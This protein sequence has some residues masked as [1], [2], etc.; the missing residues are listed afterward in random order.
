MDEFGFDPFNDPYLP[1]VQA[2]ATARANALRSRTPQTRVS[3]SITSSAQDSTVPQQASRA[4]ETPAGGTASQPSSS[5]DW[6]R[7]GLDEL[8]RDPD[9]SGAVASQRGNVD[10]A[11]HAMLLALAAQQ[12]GPEFAPVSKH[13]LGR[14]SVD[15]MKLAGATVDA[16]GN[17]VVDPE[18]QRTTI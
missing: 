8:E 9:Y 12:A 13:Y 15:P 2:R 14:A 1:P 11:Q 17:L 3:S 10:A 18:F 7:K 4:V 6:Y 5:S 16:Q